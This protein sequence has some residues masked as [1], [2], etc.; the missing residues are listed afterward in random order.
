MQHPT[1][2]TEALSAALVAAGYDPLT[3][4]E[5]QC[6]NDEDCT[7]EAL[8]MLDD[9]RAR[10]LNAPCKALDDVVD[11][12]GARRPF[13]TM[14]AD[15]L[16]RYWLTHT[17]AAEALAA[18]L[19]SLS[20]IEEREGNSAAMFAL[21]EA[22]ASVEDSSNHIDERAG[23]ILGIPYAL[24]AYN[25]SDI[26]AAVD[27]LASAFCR[28]LRE[29]IG[30]EATKE[31]ARLNAQDKDP[32]V[33]RSHDYCDANEAMSAAWVEVWKREAMTRDEDDASAWNAAWAKAKAA[34][35]SLGV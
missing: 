3:S 18:E 28:I 25:P 7:G 30:D 35:F 9:L 24:G 5:V 14:C 27:R 12:V 8:D 10:V 32:L 21:R 13:W 2:N 6:I 19:Y 26:P 1:I 29:T 20:A 4:D 34:G 16:P 33:C 22:A 23:G 11:A 31:A 17:D 15:D